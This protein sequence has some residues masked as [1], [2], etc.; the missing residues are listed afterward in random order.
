M[1]S[2]LI[3]NLVARIFR[4]VLIC[5]GIMIVLFVM[6]I[7]V[8]L[9]ENYGFLIIIP[10]IVVLMIINLIFEKILNNKKKVKDE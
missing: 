2:E 7:T 6:F 3:G 8:V 1:I 4:V 9:V 10:V 5:I